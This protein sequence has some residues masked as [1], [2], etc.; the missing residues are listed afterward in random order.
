M[1]KLVIFAYISKIES[2]LIRL[3]LARLWEIKMYL[4]RS[5]DRDAIRRRRGS[6]EI[7]SI[8]CWSIDSF[9]LL[10]SARTKT[11]R[12]QPTNAWQDV[13]YRFQLQNKYAI[14]SQQGES[15]T[16]V[17]MRLLLQYCRYNGCWYK[18][19]VKSQKMLLHV[20]RQCLQP[21]FLSAGKI[22][23][24]SLKSFTTVKNRFLR[25]FR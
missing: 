15:F 8:C 22:Y 25:I 24:F 12:P 1:W 10:Q 20:M 3:Q 7:R 9:I 14:G 16:I 11:D 4:S 17:K 18:I 21:N 19:P 23:I 2:L 5:R 6:S 13:R